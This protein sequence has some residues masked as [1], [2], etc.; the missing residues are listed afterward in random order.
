MIPQE[1]IRAKRDGKVLSADDIAAFVAGMVDGSVT[2]GQ[3]AAFA[4]AVYFKGMT[5]DE[6]V[7]L[8]RTMR[9][10]GAVLH[11]DLPGPVLDK[12][13]TGGVGDKVSL[14]LCPLVAACGAAVPQL[15]GRGLGHTGGTIDKMEAIPG[16]RATL[17]NDALV[18]QLRTVGAVIGAAG[19][20]LVPADRK[21]YALR[22]VTATVESLPLIASSI[23]S[24][25][26]AEGT[27]ALVLEVTFGSGALLTDPAEARAL[28]TTMIALGEAHGVRTSA[29]LTAMDAPLG[30]AVGNALEVDEALQCLAGGGPADVVELTLALAG[31]MLRLCGLEDGPDPAEV[32]ADGRAMDRW[33][34]MVAAQG[35]DPDAP[36]RK[37]REREIV[38]ADTDGWLVGLDARS[39]GLAA[40][41]LG[42]GRDR[43]EDAVSA[44]AGVR[45]LA[46]PGDPVRRGQPLLE[47]HTDDPAR[48]A[49]ALA[50]LD[51]ASTIG[52]APPAQSPLIAERLGRSD[53]FR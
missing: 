50:V 26:I 11:W 13:S 2:E 52:D 10:S 41:R 5:T 36:L 32:L 4:M 27:K 6:A 28:A 42:A 43:K 47:L 18:E 53:R 8:T 3:A 19:P 7:A 21:L 35:G 17:D 15:A 29:L 51:G 45:C 40:C 1:I 49:A 34:A 38:H 9:D 24:K 16:W 12:H 25:K 48:F 44:A 20:D 22:D 33:R 37:A 30:H 23:M 39:V 46:K 14:V 31:E